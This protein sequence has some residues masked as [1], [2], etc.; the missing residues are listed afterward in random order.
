MEINNR[1]IKVL[2]DA[3]QSKCEGEEHL[4]TDI[5]V[6][7]NNI[8]Y[9]IQFEYRDTSSSYEESTNSWHGTI[10]LDVMDITVYNADA[11]PLERSNIEDV[12]KVLTDKI[13]Y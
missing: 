8:S 5:E 11:E 3:L 13:S 6:I 1:T 9:F 7:D 4:C 12:K 2:E 10:Y